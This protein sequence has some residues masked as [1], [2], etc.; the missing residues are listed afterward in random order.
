MA[1]FM[2]AQGYVPAHVQCSTALRTRQTLD[3][4]L[5]ALGGEPSITYDRALYLA[6][7]PALL[8]NLQSATATPLLIVGHNPGLEQLAAA[9][10]AKPSSSA[11]K[12]RLAQLQHK[13]PTAA[14]AVLDF[15][16]PN[17]GAVEPGAGKLIAFIRPRD[18][19]EGDDD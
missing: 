15:T 10:T 16:A 17:W 12:G 2:R 9:P 3:L 1:N 19:G 13:F 8:S 7:W 14:L 5:P 6:S 11:E 18:I 4:L